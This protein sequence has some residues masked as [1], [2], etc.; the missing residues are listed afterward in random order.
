MKNSWPFDVV[1]KF[2]SHRMC[3]GTKTTAAEEEELLSDLRNAE[4]RYVAP[5]DRL[6]QMYDK[7]RSFMELLQKKRGFPEF[8]VDL[9][10]KSGQK[11]CKQVAFDAMSELFEAIQELKNS[12]DHRATDVHGF[13][14]D[15][16]V[17]ELV[18]CLHYFFEIAILSGVSADE[19]YDAFAKKD[20]VNRQR[21]ENG[22]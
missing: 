5:E 22:Y 18:D 6:L 9:A 16:Y 11:V 1:R 19:L 8:P 14:R 17:E 20:E 12:K 15:H 10:S 3:D 7:Q 13:D 4:P 21:I 2:V